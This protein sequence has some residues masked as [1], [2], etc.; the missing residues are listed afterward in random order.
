MSLLPLNRKVLVRIPYHQA[1]KPKKHDSLLAGAAQADITPPPGMPMAGFSTFSSFSRGVR[2]TLKARVFY[3]KAP[4]ERGIALIQCDLLSGSLA[5]HHR[6]AELVA[7]ETDLDTGGIVLAGTH[8]HS[9]PGNIFENHFYNKMASNAAGYDAACAEFISRQIAR[10]VIEAYKGRKKAKIATG[11]TE[12]YGVTKNRSFPAY[13]LNR[14]TESEESRQDMYRAVNPHLHM[15][16]V[17]CLDRSGTYRPL[18][19]FTSFSI[20][21][22]TNPSL[23]GRL[24]NGD[25]TGFVERMVEREI[26]ERYGT[27][28]HPLLAAANQTHGDCN[29][30]F[31][32]DYDENFLD[33]KRLAREIARATMTLFRSL[34]R[35]L[36]STVPV[37]YRARRL[38]LLR[39]GSVDNITIAKHPAP[40]YASVGGAQGRGRRTPFSFIPP[41]RPGMPKKSGAGEQ[42]HKRVALGLLG[43]LLFKT[44]HYP[45]L[46]LAQ[47]IRVGDFLMIP[48][49]W[50]VTFEMGRRIARQARESAE[51]AGMKGLG[52]AFVIDTANGYCGYVN[53]PE[54]Y[55]LQYYEGASNLYGPDTG[56]FIA[57]HA[58]RLAVEMAEKGSGSHIP[59][60]LRLKLYSGSYYPRAVPPRG[61]RKAVLEPVRC[62]RPEGKESYFRF[63][64][65]DAAPGMINLSETLVR[66]EVKG[67]KDTWSTHVVEGIAVDS[68]GMDLS[69]VLVRNYSLRAMA[70]YEARWL[71]PAGDGLYRFAIAPRG[72]FAELYSD[73]FTLEQGTPIESK[74]VK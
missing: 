26:K 54:E 15:I 10:A 56:L 71:S 36:K 57:V 60:S 53:T 22:N 72:P 18:G 69:V 30:N 9:G 44:R 40:G 45:R 28:W 73:E 17:D 34:D 63:R 2:T 20:H 29:A 3:L 16:R 66:V 21:P 61:Q 23:L 49:P 52:R 48:L 50:E 39:E 11:S 59:P 74:T 62:A 12:L 46:Y 68:Q 67:K 7:P 55:S 51:K 19:A 5:V 43:R 70:V 14:E 42:G 25:I 47:V 31:S 37:L 24:Y 6:V 65:R 27:A 33:Q 64:W 32:E 13:A 4:G 41:F 35:R 58:G 8:T 1:L 38:D